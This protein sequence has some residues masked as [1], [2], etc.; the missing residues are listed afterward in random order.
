MPKINNN[1]FYSRTNAFTLIEMLLGIII[2]AVISAV[3]YNTFWIG[4]K[5]DRASNDINRSLYEIKTAFELAANDLENLFFY[6]FSASYPTKTSFTGSSNKMSFLA[7]SSGKLQR[8]YYY[9]SIPDGSR[10]SQLIIGQRTD[11]K[12][13]APLE[14]LLRHEEGMIESLKESKHNESTGEV[15]A[16]GIKKDSF[17]INYGQIKRNSSGYIITPKEIEWF[18]EWK[19]N[20][21]PDALRFEVVLFDIKNPTEGLSLKREFYLPPVDWHA[22]K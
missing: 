17:K 2:F 10:T 11:K 15:V 3:L 9:T 12:S 8:V 4:L 16:A 1:Y 21:I 13:T 5:V 14:F 20:S 18:N 19:K 22:E 7:V 6:D